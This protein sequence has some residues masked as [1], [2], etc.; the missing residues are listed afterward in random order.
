M[1]GVVG[2]AAAWSLSTLMYVWVADGVEKPGRP[3][4]FGLLHAIW[5]LSM[6]LGSLLGGALVRVAYGLPFLIGS[7]LAA[8]SPFL[9]LAYYRSIQGVKQPG[10]AEPGS[11]AAG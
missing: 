8:V 1:F 2:V 5:C 11:E 10:A 7:A 6:I 3:S 9:A 4:A